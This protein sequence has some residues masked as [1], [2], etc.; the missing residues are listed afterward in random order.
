[1]P[2]LS[3]NGRELIEEDSDTYSPKAE[4]PG[5]EEEV[6]EET[7]PLSDR[8]KGFTGQQTPTL[9]DSDKYIEKGEFSQGAYELI[10]TMGNK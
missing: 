9:N 3:K 10:K 4:G 5:L 2:D 6:E 8:I 1:M 7:I